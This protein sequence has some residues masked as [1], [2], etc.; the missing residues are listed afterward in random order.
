VRLAG[1]EG[2]RVIPAQALYHDDG[3]N[4]LA[5]APNEILTEIMPSIEKT[6]RAVPD[7]RH[8]AMAGVSMGG[9]QTAF[10]GMNHPEAFSTL[11]LWSSAVFGDPAVL[12][13]RL[14]PAPAK[15]KNSFAYVHGRASRTLSSPEGRSTCSYFAEDQARVHAYPRTHSWLLWRGYLVDF[16][17]SAVAQ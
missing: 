7:A 11:G 2:E 1:P 5:K 4:Y 12:L 16:P 3:M 17:G 13:G 10:I 15:L 14:A 8:R 9:M 6:Y